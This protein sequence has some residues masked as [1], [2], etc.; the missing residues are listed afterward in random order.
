MYQINLCCTFEFSMQQ[1]KITNVLFIYINLDIY[2]YTQ[3]II[4]KR[5]KVHGQAT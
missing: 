4:S 3:L 1:N 5:N 2:I